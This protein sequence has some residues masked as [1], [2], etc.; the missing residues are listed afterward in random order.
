[1]KTLLIGVGNAER[2]DDAAGLAVA[3]AVRRA[4]PPGVSVLALSGEAASLIEA[5]SG[6]ERVLLVDSC[7]GAGA[8]GRVRRFEAAARPLPARWLRAS[9][10]SLGVAEAIELARSLGRLP[11]RFTVYGIEASTF[12][13]RGLSAE[14]SDAVARLSAEL[15]GHLAEQSAE[16]GEPTRTS[17]ATR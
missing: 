5:W 17:C 8:P 7:S 6:A 4:A 11:A 14:V 15:L 12:E 3:E 9:T 2:G 16:Q 13:G 10:H 1:M